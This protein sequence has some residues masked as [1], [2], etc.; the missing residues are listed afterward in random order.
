[1][2]NK[3]RRESPDDDIDNQIKLF[4]NKWNQCKDLESAEEFLKE[5]GYFNYVENGFFACKLCNGDS[6]PESMPTPSTPGIILYSRLK[7][8]SETNADQHKQSR[9]LLNLKKT[10][11][12]HLEETKTHREKL[13]MITSVKFQ[14]AERKLISLMKLDWISSDF[15]TIGF[16]E[17]ILM[18]KLTKLMRIAVESLQLKLTRIFLLPRGKTSKNH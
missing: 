8:L 4:K 11:R 7:I 3:T 14:E 2:K 18:T 5:N 12:R 17:M 13:G 10:V 1:M 6:Y 16:V 15:G 9:G